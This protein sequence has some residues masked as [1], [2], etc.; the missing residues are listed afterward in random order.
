MGR[1]LMDALL[2]VYYQ[3]WYTKVLAALKHCC[4]RALRR[5][6][7][8]QSQLVGLLTQVAESVR[9]ADK[10]RRKV[11]PTALLSTGDGL[12]VESGGCSTIESGL[13]S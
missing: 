10:N 9:L 7:E 6:L 8:L 5:E 4:G 1:L 3:G 12:T 11:Q 13:G 2:D